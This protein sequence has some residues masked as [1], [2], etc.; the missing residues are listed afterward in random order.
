[1][2]S[3]GSRLGVDSDAI[4]K[5]CHWDLGSTL[6]INRTKPLAWGTATMLSSFDDGCSREVC[7]IEVCGQ[8]DHENGLKRS[9]QGV[10]LPDHDRTPTGLLTWA[11]GAKI[12]PPDLATRHRRSSV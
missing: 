2:I 4:Q 8:R 10:T 11:I 3:S 5:I 6:E 1:V 9:C 7:T 12:N